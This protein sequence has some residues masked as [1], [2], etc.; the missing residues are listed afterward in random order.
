MVMI[1]IRDE[2]VT[3]E[4]R[5]KALNDASLSKH[6]GTRIIIAYGTNQ[7]DYFQHQIITC[8][9]CTMTC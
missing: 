6:L 2:L 3:I 8:I 5:N 7:H 1:I 9:T 4:K